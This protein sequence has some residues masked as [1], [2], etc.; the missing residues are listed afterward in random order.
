VF[1]KGVSGF[2]NFGTIPRGVAEVCPQKIPQSVQTENRGIIFAFR[3]QVCS[4]VRVIELLFGACFAFAQETL[5]TRRVLLRVNL[6]VLSQTPVETLNQ[7][8]TIELL[9]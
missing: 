6:R 2:D 8:W 3:S 4:P 7:H 1:R 9:V 5:S